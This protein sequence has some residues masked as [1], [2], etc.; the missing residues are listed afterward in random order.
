MKK[1]S[2]IIDIKNKNEIDNLYIHDTF[3][4][5]IEINHSKREATLFIE[6][7]KKRKYIIGIEG[8]LLIECEY[9]NLWKSTD[10]K[11]L[12]I[13]LYDDDIER[14]ISIKEQKENKRIIQNT[15]NKQSYVRYEGSKELIKIG[16]ELDSGDIIKIIC[17]KVI[18]TNLSS[19]NALYDYNK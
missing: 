9:L 10:Y 11:V 16:I 3:I 4:N 2:V 19:P 13:F 6:G 12:D 18:F 15:N 1:D 7:Y 17:E 5:K 14:E 8:V